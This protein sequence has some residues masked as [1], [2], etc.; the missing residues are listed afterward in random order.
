[1][2]RKTRP[3]PPPRCARKGFNEAGA[4]CPGKLEAIK[5]SRAEGVAS[6]RP[7]RN[8]PENRMGH[9]T[10]RHGTTLQ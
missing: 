6:M 8:A 2:P 7:G 4:E 9:H 1:M 3:S 10:G 5:K